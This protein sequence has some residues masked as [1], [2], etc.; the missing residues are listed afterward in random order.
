MVRRQAYRGSADLGE[1]LH[2]SEGEAP[3]ND[4]NGREAAGAGR[5]ETG[6]FR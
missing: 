3:W 2:S 1:R 4:R 5:K 6:S